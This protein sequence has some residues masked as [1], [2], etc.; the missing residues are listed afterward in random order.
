MRGVR[1]PRFLLAPPAAFTY[2]DLGGRL[3][4][5]AGR[6][7]DGWQQDGLN[8]MLSCKESKEYVCFEYAEWVPRQ[9]GKGGTLEARALTGFFVLAE[10]LIMWSAHEYK[11]AME[12]FRR[13][14]GLVINLSVAAVSRAEFLIDDPE[15]SPAPFKVKIIESHGEEGFERLDTGQRVRFIARSKQSGRGFSGDVNIVDEAFAYEL[16]MQDALLPTLGARLNPQVIYTSSPPLRGDTAPV[17][18]ALRARAERLA[19]LLATDG[20]DAYLRACAEEALGYRDFGLGGDL[21]HLGAVDLDDVENWRKANPAL[22]IRKP[23][24]RIA[25]FRKA[26]S[27]QGFAREELGIWPAEV[28]SGSKIDPKAWQDMIDVWSERASGVAVGVSVAQTR[29][30]S[31][32]MVFGLRG[33]ELGHLVVA[34]HRP[35]TEWVVPRLVELQGLSPV[36]FALGKA[37]YL[38]LKDELDAAGFTESEE[39]GGLLV[40]NGPQVAASCGQFIDAASQRAFR[41]LDEHPL[42]VAVAGAELRLTSDGVTWDQKRAEADITPLI[43]ASAALFAW[44]ERSHLDRPVDM[45]A[46]IPTVEGACPHCDAWS[47]YGG[48]IEHYDDCPVYGRVTADA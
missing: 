3:M 43:A 4:A 34:D 20:E 41:H 19:R 27:P 15:I 48:P 38:S 30:S 18:F 40:L 29:E 16:V 33:D 42:N 24:S 9:N 28:A 39:R 6:R 1:E 2:G 12:A 45:L 17:M 23:V 44:G 7:L 10:E 37:V 21:D 32:V 25:K 5:K 36:T 14:R 22:G 47:R 11:T 8:V 46:S 35:G 13:L 31:A 26:M